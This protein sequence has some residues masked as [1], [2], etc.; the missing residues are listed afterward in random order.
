MQGIQPGGDRDIDALMTGLE[1]AL[2]MM[3]V[4]H[5]PDL[6][7][8]LERLKALIWVGLM[9]VPASGTRE[10][11]PP[12]RLLEVSEAAKRLGVSADDLYHYAKQGMVT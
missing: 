2:D 8:Q 11:S 7:S 12:D 6:L 1:R 4:K 9:R 5:M 10:P 3:S